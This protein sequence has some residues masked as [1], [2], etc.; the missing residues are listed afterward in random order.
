MQPTQAHDVNV[1]A[2]E[3]P[4]KPRDLTVDKNEQRTTTNPMNLT[5]D[6]N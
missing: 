1:T 5:L 4:N 6:L 3:K 2:E